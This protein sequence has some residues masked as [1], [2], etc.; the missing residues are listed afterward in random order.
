MALVNRWY[1]ILEA[2]VAQHQ[3]KL[4]DL[5]AELS[6]S[7]HTLQKS[8]DQ[9][10]EV[11]DDDIKIKQQDNQLT[12]EVYDYARLE[13]I[14]AGSLRKE[15]DFNSSNKRSSYLIRRLIQ[16]SNPL[17]IDDLADEIGVSRTTINKDL[18][19]VKELAA[20]YQIVISGKPNRGLEVVG[21]EFN[22]RLFYIHHVYD[23]FDS[24]T[25]TDETLDFLENLY[26]D[27]KIPRKTQELLTKVISITV[28]RIRRKK[29][30]TEPIS[31]YTNELVH[32]DIME[33]LI[34]EIE[35]TYQISLS[36]Y[37]IDF[38]TFP[39]NTQFISGLDYQPAPST[40]LLQ[41][42][43]DVV[44]RVKETLL[45]NFD[46]ER[47][48]VEMHT[49]LKF[50]I[51]RLIFHV[52][53]ND[54]FHGGIKNKYPL[55]FEM[56]TV[57]GEELSEVFGFELE[58]SEISYLA[59]YFEMILRENDE[60]STSQKRQIAVVCTTGRGT[61]T[62]IRRQLTR[63]LGDDIEITQYSEEDFNSDVND[64]YFAIFTTIPLKL[65]QLKSPV[66]HIT[67][68]FDDQWLREAWQQVNHY[69]QKRLETI[70]LVFARLSGQDNYRD[71]LSEM[72]LSLKKRHLV[73]ADF[74][75]RILVREDKQSTVFGNDVAFPHTINQ[76][77]GKTV[78]MLGLLENPLETA[79]GSVEFIF[80]VA[81]P[82]QVE[83]QME[84]E[85]LELYDDIFRIAND[86]E[87]KAALRQAQTEAD[88]IAISRSKGVF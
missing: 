82:N 8:I 30:L 7:M 24:D 19:H 10:N 63:V 72:G 69:H 80:L 28:A 59:L 16:S 9:L 73:D 58:L 57:A 87:L 54:I 31:Y 56:A 52:Q 6:V 86:D 39:L 22:L 77:T 41:I 44:K 26:Q 2:L 13:D 46:E 43:Q 60:K 75:K 49:H 15:S 25:L 70:D 51:N 42:Y 84:T 66:V 32:S 40:E 79:N 81:I 47:L 64:D 4:D 21:T 65:G 83:E 20:T 33:H 23:Y 55:A 37:E 68:L 85:L 78:L 12:L 76:L 61:A 48:F 29:L 45:V 18:K 67:N 88:F 3:V 71:Y 1:Q 38:L 35:M 50:L 17:L 11:L 36:Q 53:T 74:D 34:F 14:M 27:F 62:M 5:R